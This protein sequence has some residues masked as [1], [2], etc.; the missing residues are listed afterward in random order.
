MNWVRP[1]KPTNRIGQGI[2]VLHSDDGR[3]DDYTCYTSVIR[4]EIFKNDQFIPRKNAIFCPAVN[5]GFM[6]IGVEPTYNLPV[7]TWENLQEIAR[8]GGEII[9][10]N[11]WHIYQSWTPVVIPVTAGDD[12][13][14]H[15]FNSLHF[16]E[17]RTFTIEEGLTAEEFTVAEIGVSTIPGTMG[18]FRTVNPLVNSYSTAAKMHI[19]EETAQELFEGQVSILAGYG[20]P[21]KHQVNPWYVHSERTLPWLKRVFESV[22][23][24]GGTLDINSFNLY[25]LKRSTDIRYYNTAQ[26]NVILTDFRDRNSVYFV[27]MHGAD[28]PTMRENL[29][30]V[31]NRSYE[32]GM[33]VVTHSDAIKYLKTLPG[34]VE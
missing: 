12:T 11:K 10:H 13:V 17:T 23:T 4:R 16:R 29:A 34:L 33:R 15:N 22:V 8:D 28:T 27:Q 31:I 26:L 5:A 18:W 32:L 9:S 2:V 3:L 25:D 7:M 20:I 6:D 14:Y 30:Y 19:T 1:R 24:I 21:C